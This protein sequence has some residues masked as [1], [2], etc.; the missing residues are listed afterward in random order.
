[1]KTKAFLKLSLIAGVVLLAGNIFAQDA[2]TTNAAPQLSYGVP[3]IIQLSQAKVGD[4]TIIAYIRNSGNSYNL[5]ANQIVYLRQQGLSDNVINAMLSQPKT[6]FT[7]TTSAL[8]PAQSTTIYVPTTTYVQTIPSSTV[9][10]IPDTQTYYYNAIFP[11]HYYYPG[12]YYDPPYP[13]LS[14]SFR[15]GGGYYGG[16]YRGAPHG[17]WHH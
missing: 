12:C 10:V 2:S 9:Y 11:R 5:D 8:P 17:G 14:L 16:G 7:S 4:D 13:V 6:G 15:V 3:Q 1:M